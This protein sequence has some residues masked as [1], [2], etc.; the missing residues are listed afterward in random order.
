[1]LIFKFFK[2]KILSKYTP[3]RTI[4]KKI[5]GGMPPNPPTKAHGFQI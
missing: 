3:K 2:D 1:M 4:L 5:L